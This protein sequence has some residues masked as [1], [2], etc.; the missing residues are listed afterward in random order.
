MTTAQA[1]LD[2]ISWTVLRRLDGILQGDYRSFMRGSGFD[3]ADLREYQQHDDVRHIDWNVTARLNQPYVRVFNEDREM[4]AWFIVDGS[5][6]LD[7]GSG[8]QRKRDVATDFIA[9]MATLLTRHGNRVGAALYGGP[10]A[11]A[12]AAPATA[13]RPDR[14]IPPGNSRV[15]VLSMLHS[16]KQTLIPLL[17]KEGKNLSN[18]TAT[19]LADWLH[20]AGQ[21]LKRRSTVFVLSDFITEPGW[22]TPLG[23]LAQRHDVLAVRLSDPLE[24]ALPD[25]GML[26]F[27]DAETGEDLWVD[28]HDAG[29]RQR[30]AEAAAKREADLRAAFGRCGADVL[31]L[32]TDGDMVEALTRLSQLRRRRPARAT[33]LQH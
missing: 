2:R 32:S 12:G 30:F 4:A 7:F 16:L 19:P 21:L 23:Q 6:S 33:P 29:F 20:S 9:T 5:A 1:L 18:Q 13:A 8:T 15:H 3:L 22:E 25:L 17:P 24:T 14:V 10:S 11:A 26:T 28:T 27:T 31:E